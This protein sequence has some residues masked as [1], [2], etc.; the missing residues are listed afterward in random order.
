MAAPGRCNK[1]M[2]KLGDQLE[3]LFNSNVEGRQIW[4]EVGGPPES[5]PSPCCA[6]VSRRRRHGDDTHAHSQVCKDSVCQ[7]IPFDKKRD[8]PNVV[9]V[10]R[11][12]L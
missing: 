3:E 12:E 8:G 2:E 9:N 1:V 7:G 11:M 5:M 10:E 4:D 6:P